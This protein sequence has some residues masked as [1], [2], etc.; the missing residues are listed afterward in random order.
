MSI[1]FLVGKTAMPRRGNHGSLKA[2]AQSSDHQRCW[3]SRGCSLMAST[4]EW[5]MER[6]RELMTGNFP[7]GDWA[8][9]S[10][11]AKMAIFFSLSL[12]FWHL[13]FNLVPTSISYARKINSVRDSC[14]FSSCAAFFSSVQIGLAASIDE[15]LKIPSPP[16]FTL[17]PRYTMDKK[18]SSTEVWSTLN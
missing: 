12:F 4:Y 11:G 6:I 15:Q 1:L 10:Y 7:P 2:L 9:R 3:Q 13:S 14:I 5:Y 8:G 17:L 16:P 18:A